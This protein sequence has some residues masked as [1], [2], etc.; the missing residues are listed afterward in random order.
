MSKIKVHEL[1]KELE[2][3]SRE[4]IA[5]LQEKGIEVKAAQS[6]V[7]E[8]AA[9]MVRKA[10]GA[11]KKADVKAEVKP[12]A[13]AE[14][15]PEAK[16]EAKTDVKPEVKPEVKSEAKAEP[17]KEVRK[18]A[19]KAEEKQAAPVKKKKI[20]FVSNPHNS[21]IPGQRSQGERRQGQNNRQGN[22]NYNGRPGQNRE[23]PHKIIKPLT[24]PS[25]METSTS[26]FKQN[27][28]R[29]DEARAELR[30]SEKRAAEEREQAAQIT[31]DRIVRITGMT[32]VTIIVT[33]TVVKTDPETDRTTETEGIKETIE[34]TEMT[35]IRD[36]VRTIRERGITTEDLKTGIALTTRMAREISV[37]TAVMGTVTAA[38]SIITAVREAMEGRTLDLS[39]MKSRVRVSLRIPRRL[40]MTSAERKKSAES[41]R[42]RIRDPRRISCM[43]RTKQL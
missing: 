1:A 33:I 25:Q 5:F 17:S 13:K 10:F 27:S 7:E 37:I 24:A 32:T 43:K 31:G 41:V 12:E 8:D 3:Q 36:L 9:E 30:A 39:G 4:V 23:V 22:N 20:I 6:S 15:K 21:N 29:M 18:E 40:R 26:D 11:A 2:K 19:P 42:R 16:E 14:A 38:I 34:M 35:E 28:R